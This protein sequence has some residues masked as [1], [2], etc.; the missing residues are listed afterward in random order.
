VNH[1]GNHLQET[2]LSSLNGSWA[3]HDL[4]TLANTPPVAG[5]GVPA[6]LYHAGYTSVFTV[7]EST[8]H[9]QETYLADIGAPW[10]THD[11]SD[12]AGT[13]AVQAGT[14]PAAVFHDGYVS[15][16]TVDAGTGDLQETYLSNVGAPWATHDLTAMAHTP[17][18]ADQTSP[19]TVVHSGYT[20]VYTVDGGSGHLQETYLAALGGPW[21]TQDLTAETS[22]PPVDQ[23][24]SPSAVVH[25]GYT[26]VF[27]V[28]AGDDHLQE[29]YLSAIGDNWATHDLSEMAGTPAVA[30]TLVEAPVALYHTGYTSVFTIDQ[31]SHDVQETYLSNIGNVWAT[32]DLTRIAPDTPPANQPPTALL[33]YDSAGGLTWTSI[34]TVNQSDLDLNETSLPAIGDDWSS[35]N[36]ALAAGTPPV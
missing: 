2:Y 35:E 36:L 27:T 9:L 19:A 7:D 18:V 6:S 17:P 31:G 24:A 14:S 8:G 33:H 16:F 26:S 34:F 5:P 12:L 11:L 30:S 10:A 3:T 28:D 1:P 4:N 29:T 23:A 32:H 15:V 20:S 25:S 22:G 13:P 21:A